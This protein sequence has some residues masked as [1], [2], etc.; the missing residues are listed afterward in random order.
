MVQ[1]RLDQVTDSFG[2]ADCQEL[3][4]FLYFDQSKTS[5]RDSVKIYLV[6]QRGPATVRNLF[7]AMLSFLEHYVAHN[8]T[9]VSLESNLIFCSALFDCQSFTE[10]IC[11]SRPRRSVFYCIW[12]EFASYVSYEKVWKQFSW[13]V[14]STGCP[15]SSFLY[16]IS[17]FQYDWTW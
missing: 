15:K 6:D 4:F 5:R 2:L 17:L 11:L 10:Y 1:Q 8:N 16:F 12:L 13:E 9:F 14:I 7:W 3:T